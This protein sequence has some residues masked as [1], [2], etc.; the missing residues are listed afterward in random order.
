MVK[1][2]FDAPFKSSTCSGAGIVA[3]FLVRAPSPVLAKALAFTWA[4]VL[5]SQLG[6]RHVCF[7]TDCLQLFQRLKKPPDGDSYLLSIIRECFFFVVL[8]ILLL[9]PLCVVLATLLRIF[10][11]GVP[12]LSPVWCG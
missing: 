12:L 11:L 5:A 4:V 7:E 10:L 8:L 1:I 3:S 2:N 9:Y 6:F